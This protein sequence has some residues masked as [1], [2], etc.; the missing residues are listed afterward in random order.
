[1]PFTQMLTSAIWGFGTAAGVPDVA[2][3]DRVSR[4]NAE[5]LAQEGA[6]LA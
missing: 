4:E 6:E 5:K 2:Q 1:M 3:I